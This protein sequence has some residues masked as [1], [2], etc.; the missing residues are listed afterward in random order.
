LQ[1]ARIKSAHLRA[2]PPNISEQLTSA[3]RAGDAPTKRR[4]GG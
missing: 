4:S 3:A 1:P 2:S